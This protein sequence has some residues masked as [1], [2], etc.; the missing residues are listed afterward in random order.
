MR[1]HSQ[2]K[3]DWFGYGVWFIFG[4][5]V[6]GLPVF[7]LHFAIETRT[8]SGWQII[9]LLSVCCLSGGLYGGWKHRRQWE[10]ENSAGAIVNEILDDRG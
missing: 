4:A 7:V 10:L 2:R 5:L 1:R 3:Y 9:G 8:M 6:S